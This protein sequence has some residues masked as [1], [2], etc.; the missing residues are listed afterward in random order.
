MRSSHWLGLELCAAF[1]A[2][3]VTVGWHGGHTAC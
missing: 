3:T 1:R 2:L